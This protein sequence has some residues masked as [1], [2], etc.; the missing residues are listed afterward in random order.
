MDSSAYK[1]VP[2]EGMQFIQKNFQKYRDEAAVGKL[3]SSTSGKVSLAKR[4]Q[5]IERGYYLQCSDELESG[6]FLNS[7]EVRLECNVLQHDK[8]NSHAEYPKK[9]AVKNGNQSVLKNK[10]QTAQINKAAD[11]EKNASGA[12]VQMKLQELAI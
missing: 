12:S 11:V 8:E 7:A 9:S 4:F 6:T 3:V 10:K 1:I 2:I 5:L